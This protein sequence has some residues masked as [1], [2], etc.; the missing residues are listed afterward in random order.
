MVMSKTRGLVPAI[1]AA[2]AMTKA[3]EVRLIGREFVGGGYVTV[4]VRGETGAVNAAV[5]AGAASVVILGTDSPSV[6]VAYVQQAFAALQRREVVLGPSEDGGYYL[7][8]LRRDLPQ[9]F[10]GIAW[11]TTRVW[12][13]TTDRLATTSAADSYEILPAW[14]DV[15]DIEDLSRLT[16]ELSTMQGGDPALTGLLRQLRRFVAS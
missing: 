12:Q 11:S 5:R 1:G 9:L 6:P 16:R 14:Y 15:D 4:L 13:Q 2:D 10:E 8:G 3:A 7:I